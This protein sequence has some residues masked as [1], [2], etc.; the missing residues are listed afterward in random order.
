MARI[1]VNGA[2]AIFTMSVKRLLQFSWVN[3]RFWHKAEIRRSGT[4][5]ESGAVINLQHVVRTGSNEVVN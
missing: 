5:H 4:F 2:G 3:V 1:L